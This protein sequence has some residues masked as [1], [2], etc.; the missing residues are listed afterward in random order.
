MKKFVITI[1]SFIYLLSSI[2]ITVHFHYC[3]GKLASWDLYNKE[4]AICSK[5]GME[6]TE[7]TN[8]GCCTDKHRFLKNNCDQKLSGSFFT[9]AEQMQLLVPAAGAEIPATVF[10]VFVTE[11]IPGSHA[12]PLHPGIPVFLLNRNFRI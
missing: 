5:C 6:K 8:K 2:G 12:P 10:S 9:L 4:S 1:L 7:T 3:M 11:K